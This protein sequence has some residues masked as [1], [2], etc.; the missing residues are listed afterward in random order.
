MPKKELQNE[1]AC[2]LLALKQTSSGFEGEHI[3]RATSAESSRNGTAEVEK[4]SS[5]R[6]TV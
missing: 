2:V 5:R 6:T 4:G 1:V 3:A